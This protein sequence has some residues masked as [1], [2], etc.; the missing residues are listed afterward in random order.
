MAH[1]AEYKKTE[2]EELAKMLNEYPVIGIINLENLP[3]SQLQKMRGRLRS[4]LTIRMS[5]KTL[6]RHAF[7]KVKNPKIRELKDYLIGMPAMV[8]TNQEPFKIALKL[9]KSKSSAP[10][11]PGQTSPKDLII[12][13]GPTSFTPGPIISELGQ[14]GIKAGVDKGKIVVKE[15]KVVARKGD[16]IDAKIAAVL[17]KFG[18]EPMEI[19]L[20]LVALYDN[21]VIYSG[22][23]L[24]VDDKKLFEDLR[25]AASWAFSLAV[26]TGYPAKEVM[27]II[28]AKAFRQA[29]AVS[30]LVP[31]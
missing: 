28:I 19:G 1:V 12:P 26:E 7:E 2:V 29:Q 6:L 23:A 3:T 16:K 25:M 10:A 22:D 31:Q 27:P 9:R 21:G 11:K 30:A 20:N 24:E 4:D 8:F 15:D 13:A 18:I 5:K 14:L 17:Q